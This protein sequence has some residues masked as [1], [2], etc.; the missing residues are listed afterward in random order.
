MKCY[1]CGQE[2]DDNSTFCG[3]CGA[4]Q[5][6]GA[7]VVLDQV[8]NPYGQQPE[9]PAAPAYEP[10]PAYQAPAY[11]A[12]AYQAPAYQAPA[13]EAPAYQAP[14]APVYTPAAPAAPAAA[15]GKPVCQHPTN[16]AWWKM[17]LLGLVTFGI[18]PMVIMCRI[19]TELNVAASRYDGKRTMPYFAMTMLTPVTLGILSIVWIHKLCNRIGDELKRRGI[20]YKFSAATYWLWGVLG[21]MIFVGPF[22]Y[23]HKFMKAMN[24]INADFNVNG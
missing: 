11:E 13:Y 3:F 20:D 9:A 24:K 5:G 15:A 18:Y 17:I 1:H 14:Q 22:V 21:S 6:A 4:N 12:P 23:L 19:P 7:T 16:R 8:Y 10:A 2:I